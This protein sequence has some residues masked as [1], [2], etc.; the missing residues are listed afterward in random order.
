MFRLIKE[1]FIAL[2]SFMGSLAT[3]SLSLD[4]EPCVTRPARID[5]NPI[6]RNC[7]PFMD[8]CKSLWDL[9]QI[10]IN[11]ET[12]HVIYQ[13]LVNFL[14]KREIYANKLKSDIFSI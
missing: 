7:Y 4:N 9:G 3:K 5:L 6:K 10:G 14:Q 8:E 12:K 1:V 13:K 11:F 2:L